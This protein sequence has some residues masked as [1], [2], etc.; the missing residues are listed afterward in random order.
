MPDS[1]LITT[2]TADTF[3]VTHWSRRLND[4]LTKVW[5]AE[6]FTDLTDALDF[7]AE[8]ERRERPSLHVGRLLAFK[9]GMQ[10][11][12]IDTH[13]CLRELASD[14]K[15]DAAHYRAYLQGPGL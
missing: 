6:T 1:T 12:V 9:D 14:R 4:R 11:G 8:L 7:Y 13:A 3:V 10:I 2:Q 5:S 15:A